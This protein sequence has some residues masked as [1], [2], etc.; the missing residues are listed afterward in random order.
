[1][2]KAYRITFTATFDDNEKRHSAA[3]AL[4]ANLSG[5]VSKAAGTKNADMVYD[6]FE[7]AVPVVT[8][9]E[10]LPIV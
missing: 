4:K 6:E 3:T 10:V 5:V 8:G 1:M 9:H 2:A 7:V